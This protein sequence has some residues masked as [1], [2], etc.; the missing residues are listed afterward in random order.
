MCP[1]L[2]DVMTA[3]HVRE[4]KTLQTIAREVG[5]SQ[6]YL[7]DLLHGRRGARS[8]AKW[9]PRIAQAMGI[10]LEDLLKEVRAVAEQNTPHEN[11][12]GQ[13]PATPGPLA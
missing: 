2:V 6:S 7:H 5:I 10:S 12:E 1:T 4:R 11:T 3:K 13:E 9:A 8:L